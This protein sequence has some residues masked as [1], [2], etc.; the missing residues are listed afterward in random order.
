MTTLI[1]AWERLHSA[2]LVLA[3]SDQPVRNRLMDATSSNLGK[4]LVE[5]N[6]EGLLEELQERLAHLHRALTEKGS[7]QATIER[8]D[9]AQVKSVVEIL[10]GLYHDM[11][12]AFDQSKKKT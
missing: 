1:Y 6:I 8:M 10:L 2:L 12:I 11:S 7:Y 4:I 9:E 3:S 5:R